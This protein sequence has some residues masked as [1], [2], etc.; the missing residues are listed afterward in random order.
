MKPI[1]AKVY[2]I[3][4]CPKCSCEWEKS[5]KEAQRLSGFFCQNCEE[6]CTFDPIEKVDVIP[7]YKGHKPQVAQQPV[8]SPIVTPVTSP[9]KPK[10]PELSPVKADAMEAL[11]VVGFKRGFAQSIVDGCNFDT[12]EAYIIEASRKEK[13]L[14]KR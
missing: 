7:R 4:R 8:A 2:L 14:K 12:V 9:T 5:I 13:E 3:Y 6:F 1:T 11:I 10:K